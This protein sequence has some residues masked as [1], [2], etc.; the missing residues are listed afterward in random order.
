MTPQP[1]VWYLFQ[2]SNDKAGPFIAVHKKGLILLLKPVDNKVQYYVRSDD[3][4]GDE[5][6]PLQD[7]SN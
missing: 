6:T 7:T 2:D 3:R 4:D 1:I 5:T